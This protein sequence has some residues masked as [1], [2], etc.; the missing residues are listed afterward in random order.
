MAQCA[1]SDQI[2]GSAIAQSAPPL[3][4]MDSK[5]FYPPARLTTPYSPRQTQHHSETIY[6]AFLT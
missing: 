1:E 2:F 3:N 5:I 4:V 6:V